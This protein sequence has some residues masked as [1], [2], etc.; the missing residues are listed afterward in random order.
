MTKQYNRLLVK[1]KNDT[2]LSY[3]RNESGEGAFVK[4]IDTSIG[5]KAIMNCTA[6][7]F[8]NMKNIY[9]LLLAMKI[10]IPLVFSKLVVYTIN[11]F[12][13]EIEEYPLVFDN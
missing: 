7:A 12:P 2:L 13:D 5:L 9:F 4:V 11:S 8:S 3:T 6:V 1:L 10:D